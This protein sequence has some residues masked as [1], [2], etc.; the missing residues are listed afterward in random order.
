MK[1][2]PYPH[3]KFPSE[4]IIKATKLSDKECQWFNVPLGSTEL[5]CINYGWF[6][7]NEIMGVI[8]G[9]FSDT[10]NIGA[11]ISGNMGTANIAVKDSEKAISILKE[12][13]YII[14]Q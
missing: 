6:P 7:T 10:N 5:S 11:F 13:G 14:N 12:K 8:S 4:I 2:R 9:K 1:K 3:Y